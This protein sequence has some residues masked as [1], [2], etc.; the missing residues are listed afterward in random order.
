M[1]TV[2]L[3][4]AAEVLHQLGVERDVLV[5]SDGPWARVRFRIIDGDLEVQASIIRPPELLRDRRCARKRI[6]A[7]IR[8]PVILETRRPDDERVAHPPARR[9]A[10]EGRKGIDRGGTAIGEDLPKL[11]V[12]FVEDD[13]SP[14]ELYNLATDRYEFGPSFDSPIVQS[15]K[16]QPRR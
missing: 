12:F 4:L 10:V 15:R 7:T 8:P 9:V 6:A 1:R 2:F 13:D 3:V 14:W 5:K 16:Q 11:I